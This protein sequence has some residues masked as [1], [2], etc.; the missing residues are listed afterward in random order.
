[1]Q[2]LFGGRDRTMVL[3]GQS[4]LSWDRLTFLLGHLEIH[5]DT[6]GVNRMDV[7]IRQQGTF[8]PWSLCYI[9]EHTT[10]LLCAEPRDRIFGVLKLIEHDPERCL[11]VPDYNLSPVQLAINLVLGGHFNTLDE[12][13]VLA[14]GMALSA[15]EV[16]KFRGQV[17][18]AHEKLHELST[19]V[20][21]AYFTE[22]H[23]RRLHARS[24]L[25]EGDVSDDPDSSP[26]GYTVDQEHVKIFDEQGVVAPAHP[27]TKAGD[28]LLKTDLFHVVV[29]P[30][31][32]W[33][34]FQVIGGAL[35]F[36]RTFWQ[37]DYDNVHC[38][39]MESNLLFVNKQVKDRT[40]WIDR[41][42]LK[43]AS[44]PPY[45]QPFC[46]RPHKAR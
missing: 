1:V 15:D 9:L 36:A 7:L 38:P 22:S 5:S 18:G 33:R 43:S 34:S 41:T 27:S 6:N 4:T 3:C 31:Q 11:I 23:K 28:L 10:D 8:R 12:I 30:Q 39:L 32:Q 24:P 40:G 17:A 42:R 45:S 25:A 37:D 44:R 14:K 16:A 2:E 21:S 13:L 29:R 46:R 35:C 26:E 19:F 20:R